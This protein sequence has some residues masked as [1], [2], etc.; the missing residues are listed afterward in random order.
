MSCKLCK[1]IVNDIVQHFIPDCPVLYKSRDYLMH[2]VV[3][4]LTVNTNVKLTYNSDREK[5][6][7]ILGFNDNGVIA[8]EEWVICKH[9]APTTCL[10]DLISNSNSHRK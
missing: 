1:R 4:S 2:L 8:E 5:V 6:G 3:N 9:T 10:M 7:T